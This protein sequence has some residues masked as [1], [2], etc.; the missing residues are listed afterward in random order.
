M[1]DNLKM[2]DR[3][4]DGG[5][6]HSAPHA[7]SSRRSNANARRVCQPE[8]Q[9]FSCRRLQPLRGASASHSGGGQA[10][11]R[12]RANQTRRY[13]RGALRRT[14]P[15][16]LSQIVPNRAASCWQV[17]RNRVRRRDFGPCLL[18]IAGSATKGR[19]ITTSKTSAMTNINSATRLATDDPSAIPS[20]LRGIQPL[21]WRSGR[22]RCQTLSNQINSFF[23]KGGFHGIGPDRRPA[24]R[25]NNAPPLA[26][27]F[28]APETVSHRNSVRLR[29]SGILP[30]DNYPCPSLVKPPWQFAILSLHS[31][32]FDVGLNL[33]ER[34]VCGSF[35]KG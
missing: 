9:A 32:R 20:I 26:S 2:A 7:D 6:R 19:P 24:L 10:V 35:A 29:I 33:P 17:S 22:A 5:T 13:A 34:R 12:M 4:A 31:P 21:G 8:G 28:C 3:S 15:T 11:E 23:S 1:N 18:R 30:S 16:E 25:S 14:R 27:P